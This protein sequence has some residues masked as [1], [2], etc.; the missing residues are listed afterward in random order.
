MVYYPV[1][2]LGDYMFQSFRHYG[3][4]LVIALFV[5]GVLLSNQAGV[6]LSHHHTLPMF[7]KN[8]IVCTGFYNKTCEVRLGTSIT[9][10]ENFK[11]VLSLLSQAKSGDT[12]IF[13]LIGYGGQVD[14]TTQLLYAIRT[15][16]ATTVAIVQGSVYSAH[17]YIAVSMNKMIINPLATFMFHRSSAYGRESVCDEKKGTIDRKQ[18]A[19]KKCMDYLNTMLEQDK[20]EV[21]LTLGP[22]LTKVE[23]QAILDGHDV[24]VQGYEMQKRLSSKASSQTV[25]QVQQKRVDSG[26]KQ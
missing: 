11:D 9:K 23:L 17:A 13:Y 15:T 14:T 26:K 21:I 6:N 10:P 16:K 24:Y 7:E 1:F 18:D 20:N 3:I 4:F 2:Y 19:Y 22:F 5:G 25:E 12:I 8:K